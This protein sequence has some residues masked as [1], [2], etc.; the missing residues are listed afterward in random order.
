MNINDFKH[1][2]WIKIWAGT[3]SFLS[4]SHF[5]VDFTSRIRFGSWPFIPQAII[6]VAEGKSHCWATQHDRDR[7]GKFL[8]AEVNANPDHALEVCQTLKRE[9]DI[10]LGVVDSLIKDDIDLHVYQ[11]FWQQVVRYYHPHINVKYVVDYLESR[12]LQKLL[13]HFEEARVYAE[14]VFKRTEDFILKL[15]DT[16]G[17]K[18]NLPTPLILCF[19]T[20][21]MEA[22]LVRN[23]VPDQQILEERNKHSALL[24]DATEYEIITG[25]KVKEIT[26]LVQAD[27]TMDMVRGVTAFGG[28]IRGC[29]RVVLDPEQ[30]TDFQTGDILVAG[31]TRP[32]YLPLMQKAGAIVTDAGGILCHAAIVARE[33]KKPCVIGTQFAT[34]VFKDGDMVE[35]DADRGVVKKIS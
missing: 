4:C 31:M 27:E 15:A 24:F 7:L 23:I 26:A 28:S 35:V 20:D 34:K 5:G 17:E 13:P 33:M 29:V 12:A 8:A 9:V 14:P 22:Y 32:E 16:V 21:E 3:W 30:V 11:Q 1:N 18:I 2:D 25:E 6:F 19:S 10:I